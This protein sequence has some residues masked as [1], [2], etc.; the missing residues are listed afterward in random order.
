MNTHQHNVNAI[1]R[2][3]S[4]KNTLVIS[5]EKARRVARAM[6]GAAGVPLAVQCGG[7]W[8]LRLQL[9]AGQMLRLTVPVDAERAAEL[10]AVLALDGAAELEP[11]PVV[12]PERAAQLATLRANIAQL[13]ARRDVGVKASTG[14]APA[15]KLPAGESDLSWT[16]RVAQI[17]R[18]RPEQGTSAYRVIRAS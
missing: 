2:N 18:Q 10:G 7:Y 13:E 17:A 11:A 8:T 6:I 15:R 9:G 14:G 12:E 5:V 3:L 1:V 4:S 16:V